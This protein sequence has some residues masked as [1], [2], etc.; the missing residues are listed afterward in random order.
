MIQPA[1]RPPARNETP[2]PS[3]EACQSANPIPI[4]QHATLHAELQS[5]STAARVPNPFGSKYR[6]PTSNQRPCVRFL[7]GTRCSSPACVQLA[8]GVQNWRAH[9][10]LNL[11]PVQRLPF[12]NTAANAA[13]Q[14]EFRVRMA[15]RLPV[16]KS[17]VSQGI[18]HDDAI[19]A[20]FVFPERGFIR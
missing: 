9:A 4:T 7:L 13:G 15:R 2:A 8:H 20:F 17:S 19:R 3:L 10:L 6:M 18:P 14:S 11:Q 16:W 1:R 12:G 5:L